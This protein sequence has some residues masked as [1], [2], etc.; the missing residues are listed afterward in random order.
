VARGGGFFK[1][2]REAVSSFFTGNV[3]EPPSRAPVRQ[4][5]ERQRARERD[6]YLADWDGRH[7]NRTG[8]LNHK[9]LIDDMALTYNLDESEKRELWNDY[10]KYIVGRK[11]ERASYRR[12]DI[13]NPFWQ[14]WGIDPDSF[15]WDAWREA[16]GY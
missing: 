10:M 7:L 4:G 6:P 11:D 15:D 13:H 12:N 9:D 8:Y 14:K 3:E 1:R 5:R 16:M 2:I